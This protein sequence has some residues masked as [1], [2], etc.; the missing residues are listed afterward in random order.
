MSCQKGQH[1][2]NIKLYKLRNSLKERF[3][4]AVE[5]ITPMKIEKCKLV[6]KEE[7]LIAKNMSLQDQI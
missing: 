7:Y 3:N 5:N 2:N 4:V 1:P 6:P